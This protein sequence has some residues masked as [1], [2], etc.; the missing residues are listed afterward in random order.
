MISDAEKCNIFSKMLYNTFSDNQIININNDNRVLKLLEL[1]DYSALKPM[2]YVTPNEI[3]LIIKKV[4][5][6]KSPRHDRITNTMFKNLPLYD[7]IV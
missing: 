5:N 2:V 1:S 7:C 3:K 4:P 6:K